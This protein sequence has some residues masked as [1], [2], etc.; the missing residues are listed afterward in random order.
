MDNK[1]IHTHA[2]CNSSDKLLP[3]IS[4]GQRLILFMFVTCQTR[5][6]FKLLKHGRYCE[7]EA[8]VPVNKEV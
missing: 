4:P 2:Y 8:R 3:F 1:L 6:T 5:V 7:F